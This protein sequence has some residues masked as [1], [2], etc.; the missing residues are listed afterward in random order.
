M[1]TKIKLLSIILLS[2]LLIACEEPIPTGEGE[3]SLAFSRNGDTGQSIDGF[4]V[5]ENKN[6]RKF[7]FENLSFYVSDIV[8]HKEGGDTLQLIREA[9]GSRTI[10]YDWVDVRTE[11][12]GE[13]LFQKFTVP[14]GNYTAVSFS[15]GVPEEANHSDP[16]NYPAE[17][18]LSEFRGKHWTWNAGYRFI[19]ADGWIDSTEN[20][21]GVM[22]SPFLYHC[23]TDTLLRSL[24]YT[25]YDIKITNGQTYTFDFD[26]DPAKMFYKDNEEVNMIVDNIT[27][28][29]DFF[30]VALSVTENFVNNAIQKK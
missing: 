3:F 8:L 17:H 18:P 28:T 20:M 25:G 2:S 29:G 24:S 27:H 9:D 19:M 6:G 16:T 5:F 23:G 14:A 12:E 10:L 22:D 15:I 4:P 13:N 1:N 7:Y 21:T 11:S 30:P 26:F